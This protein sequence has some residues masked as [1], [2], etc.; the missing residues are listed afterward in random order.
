[1]HGPLNVKEEIQIARSRTATLH[2]RRHS[3]MLSHEH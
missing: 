3:A 2:M 1:M